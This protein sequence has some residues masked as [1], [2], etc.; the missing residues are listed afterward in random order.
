MLRTVLLLALHAEFSGVVAMT[1]WRQP[2]TSTSSS[3][4]R[5]GGG[6]GGGG[7]DAG[8]IASVTTFSGGT[9]DKKAYEAGQL[10]AAN[11]TLA[12][13]HTITS[14]RPGRAGLMTF[15]YTLGGKDASGRF[16]GDNTRQSRR[17]LATSSKI[18]FAA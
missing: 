14:P 1:R 6:G 17:H 5:G 18:C 13:E 4:T 11:E 8:T 2:P 12:F 3:A 16:L 10:F 15:L 7:A 9:Y